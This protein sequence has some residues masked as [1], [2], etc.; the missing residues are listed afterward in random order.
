MRKRFVTFLTKKWLAILIAIILLV[1]CIAGILLMVFFKAP[2]ATEPDNAEK[3]ALD[4]ETKHTVTFY[5]DDGTVLKIDS[6]KENSF[7]TP[8]VAPEMTYGMVFK[9]WDTDFSK[10]TEDLEVHPVCE[11]IR[12]KPN[13]LAVES[14]YTREDNT[15]VVPLQLSGDVCVSGLDITVRYDPESIKLQLVTEDAAVVVNDATPGIIKLNYVST[16]NTVADVDICN[17]KFLANVREGIIPVTVEIDGVYAF[18]DEDQ[19]DKLYV[20]ECT[21]IDGNVF[22]IG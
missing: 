22:V 19:M 14:R 6:V 21:I 12:G 13:V 5:S 3:T 20:P 7:A 2:L 17:F 11:E 16:E 10:V 18:E 8:P 15:V 1:S 4:N 9:A